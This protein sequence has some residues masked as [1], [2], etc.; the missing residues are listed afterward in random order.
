MHS[1]L[2]NFGTPTFIV[3]EKGKVTSV[4]QGA[5]GTIAIKSLLTNYGFISE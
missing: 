3:I 5:R 2:E 1:D 4:D